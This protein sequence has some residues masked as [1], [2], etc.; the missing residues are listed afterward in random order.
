MCYCNG[1]TVNGQ[2][3]DK[4]VDNGHVKKWGNYQQSYYDNDLLY[5]DML[6]PMR[7]GCM[8]IN[9]KQNS[10][11]LYVIVKRNSC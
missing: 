2:C 10:P 11:A 6:K 5:S 3:F 7:Y 8:N 1:C 9:L 4:D